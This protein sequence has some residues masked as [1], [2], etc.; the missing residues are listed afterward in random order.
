MNAFKTMQEQGLLGRESKKSYLDPQNGELWALVTDEG[1]TQHPV[2]WEKLDCVSGDTQL[3]TSNWTLFTGSP[4]DYASISDELES[5]TSRPS[6]SMDELLA[7][8]LQEAENRKT[9]RMSQG[10][11]SKSPLNAS[12]RKKDERA[13]PPQ[14]EAHQ[15]SNSNDDCMIL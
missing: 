8:Q 5:E 4:S 2:V 3:V 10:S 7:K 6:S 14:A 15:S 11:G 12:Q 13:P 9:V 1:Y